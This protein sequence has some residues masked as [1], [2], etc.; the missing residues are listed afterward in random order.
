MK[1]KKVIAGFW[2]VSAVSACGQF[3]LP[4]DNAAR[5]HAIAQSNRESTLSPLSTLGV[6]LFC[7]A[8]FSL[9]TSGRLCVK[10]N[11][12]LGPFTKKMIAGCKANGGGPSCDTPIWSSSLAEE[13]RGTGTCMAGAGV[14]PSGL[15]AEGEE[16]YGPF[17][18][19][20][21]A[22]C[23]DKGGGLACESMRIQRKFA[24]YTLPADQSFSWGF[25]AKKD[26]GVRSDGYGSGWFRAARGDGSRL[27]A[28]IDYLFARGTPLYS[29]CKGN[30]ETGYDEGGYGYYVVVVCRI[31][32]SL[33]GDEEMYAS[34]LYGHLDDLA[35]RGSGSVGK[36]QY[37][38]DVGKSGNADVPGLNPHVHFEIS[39]E[40][41][42]FSALRNDYSMNNIELQSVTSFGVSSFL[43]KLQS[44]CLNPT[45]FRST[46]GLSYGSRVDPFVMLSCLSNSKPALSY[47]GV[48][49]EFLKWSQFYSA[50]TFDVNV[51][52]R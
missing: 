20:H 45:G 50:S 14:M 52:R 3:E 24:E 43:D 19:E 7:P 33:A 17:T 39:I 21:V 37:I 1:L 6:S 5:F 42:A 49:D 32:S 48:Q 12:A 51:G 15:C 31:P 4:S 28:G 35:V 11:T 29:P 46:A 13:L 23:K 9:S 36:G 38:G 40:D 2:L 10:G 25:I 34:M 30:Y 27:H 22:N 44:R 16:A 8:G 18:K 47:S 41:N 26:N